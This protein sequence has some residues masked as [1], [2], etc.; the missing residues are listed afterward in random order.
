MY[1]PTPGQHHSSDEA[2]EVDVGYV[3]CTGSK[4]CSCFRS[5]RPALNNTVRITKNMNENVY[6]AV[7]KLETDLC[8]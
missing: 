3:N 8:K 4:N 1:P 5:N 7:R 2:A 6:F